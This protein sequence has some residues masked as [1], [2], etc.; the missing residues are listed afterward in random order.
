VLEDTTPDPVEI[1]HA[2]SADLDALV[3][4]YLSLAV[5]HAALAPAAYHVPEASAVRERFGLVVADTDPSNL[6][7]VAIVEGLVV[8][9]LDA[10]GED[11]AG[12]GSTRR[13]LRAATIGI[14][15][16]E[17]WRGH[18]VGTALIEAAERWARDQ[19]LDE[20]RMEVAIE[21]DDARRLY[22]RLGYDASNLLLAKRVVD[23]TGPRP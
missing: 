11:L 6:H 20:V 13:P 18:G 3:D 9:Q 19:D 10:W 14:A 21:N 16:L 4:V 22:E 15:V 23:P 1:R 12:P 7:L 5:H 17:A 2:T 8:G